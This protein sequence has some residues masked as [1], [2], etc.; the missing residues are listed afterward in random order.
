MLKY[1]AGNI[2]GLSEAQPRTKSCFEEYHL[3]GCG[4][5]YACVEPSHSYS[6]INACSH[7]ELY[8][9][10]FRYLMFQVRP[11]MGTLLWPEAEMLR[12][13]E[14]FISSVQAGRLAIV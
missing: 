3:F 9:N 1:P 2:K 14:T 6:L 12:R 4:V 13:K 5:L 8:H 7:V 10:F 11:G